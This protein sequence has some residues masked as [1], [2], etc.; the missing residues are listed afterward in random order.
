MDDTLKPM[1]IL[2]IFLFTVYSAEA[3][4][5]TTYNVSTFLS[6]RILNITWLPR[7]DVDLGFLK[8]VFKP[9]DMPQLSESKYKLECDFNY[10]ITQDQVLVP[11]PAGLVKEFEK[12]R[13]NESELAQTRM[14]MM[15]FLLISITVATV[16][17]AYAMYNEWYIYRE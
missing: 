15:F 10:N 16:L 3:M 13:G 9:F 1:I 4:N 7:W 5:Y 6:G 17:F 14:W 8:C 11:L 12:L 2:L